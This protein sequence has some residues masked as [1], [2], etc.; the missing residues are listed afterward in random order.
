MARRRGRGNMLQEDFPDTENSKCGSPEGETQLG[1]VQKE[2]ED[3]CRWDDG[4]EGA[5]EL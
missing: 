5:A 4:A 2:H 3:Q 1:Q